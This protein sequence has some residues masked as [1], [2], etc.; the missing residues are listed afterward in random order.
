[1]TFFIINS[2]II[3]NAIFMRLKH[4]NPLKSKYNGDK[5]SEKL[6]IVGCGIAAISAVKAILEVS[7]DSQ[8]HMYGDENFYPYNRMKLSKNLFEELGE[9]TILLQ[10]KDWYNANNVNLHLNMKVSSIDA[11]RQEIILSDGTRE[12]YDKLLLA[13][14]ARNTLPPINGINSP[15]VYTIRDLEDVRKIK[16]DIDNKQIILNIGAGSQGLE[17][18]WVLGQH[19][20]EVVIVQRNRR[21]MPR[22]LD[23]KASFI[24]KY[25]VEKSNIRVLLNTQLEMIMSNGHMECA[26]KDGNK[27]ICDAVF[28]SAG[29]SPNIEL[30]ENTPVKVNYGIIVDKGMHTNIENIYAAGDI[31]ELNGR[32]TGLWNTAIGQ[33]KTAGYN[34]AGKQAAYEHIVPVTTLNAFGISLF[35]MGNVSEGENTFTLTTEDESTKSYKRLFF[36][37]NR[38]IGAIAIGDTKKSPVIKAAI[39]NET[40]IKNVNLERITVDELL[41]KLKNKE[42]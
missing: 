7:S 17:I 15:G 36:E 35:S 34:M 31:A 5:M 20:K 8:I 38:I 19:G 6:I 24:L 28:Y 37:N 4:I 40:L 23:E 10:K 25:F 32:I 9:D 33:G 2:I 27:I 41:E 16:N 42:V 12:K 29:I 22:E 30:L 11:L 14:G 21:L 26:T 39:E 18:A 1:L 3:G 13:N